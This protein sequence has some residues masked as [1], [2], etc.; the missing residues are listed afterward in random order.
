MPKQIRL[1]AAL[2]VILCGCFGASHPIGDEVVELKAE[3]WEGVWLAYGEMGEVALTIRVADASKGELEVAWIQEDEGKLVLKSYDV[4][5]RRTDDWEFA[6][7]EIEGEDHPDPES[8]EDWYA[9][10]R[11]ENEDGKQ[12]NAWVP[13]FERLASLIRESALPGRV[14]T[15]ETYLGPLEPEHMAMIVSTER[16]LFLWEEPMILRRFSPDIPAV[17][18]DE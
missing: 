3:E 9:F 5:L 10:F 13:D 8:G 15:Y 17:V 4:Q 1:V 14:T 11:I 6:N 12:I 16:P 2:A 7:S 18:D